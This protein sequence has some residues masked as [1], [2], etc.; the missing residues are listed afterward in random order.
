MELPQLTEKQNACLF[1]YFTNGHKKGE[2][3]RSAYDTSKMSENATNVEVSR[4]FNDPKIALYL[5]YYRVNQ[6]QTIQEQLNYDALKHFNELNE[7]KAVALT[8]LDR[9]GNPNINAAIK[10]VE[11]KGK[12]A[13]LYKNENEDAQGNN[14]INVMGSITVDGKKLDFNVGEAVDNENSTSENP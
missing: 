1:K 8:C 10:T 5:E 7:M 12:L 2:A 6:Q 14:V 13:G 3:Y 4:F 11:L 9:N